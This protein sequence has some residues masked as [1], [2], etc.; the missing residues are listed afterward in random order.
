MKIKG[1]V[2]IFTYYFP[3]IEVS[4]WFEYYQ[5]PS[6][7]ILVAVLRGALGCVARLRFHESI[8]ENHFSGGNLTKI[9]SSHIIISLAGISLKLLLHTSNHSHFEHFLS[10]ITKLRKRFRVFGHIEESQPLLVFF[11]LLD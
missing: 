4:I 10:L 2:F 8:R 9:T 3:D 5:N 1:R 7:L 11:L 6:S